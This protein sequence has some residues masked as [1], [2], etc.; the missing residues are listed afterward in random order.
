MTT[1][2]GQSMDAKFRRTLA[3]LRTQ[4][5]AVRSKQRARAKI[6]NSLAKIDIDIDMA[7]WA[8]AEALARDM[9]MLPNGGAHDGTYKARIEAYSEA[10]GGSPAPVTIKAYREMGT[11][12]PKAKRK[13]TSWSAHFILKSR[14]ELLQ[15]GMTVSEAEYALKGRYGSRSRHDRS[16]ARGLEIFRSGIRFLRLAM[17]QTEWDAASPEQLRERDEL[18]GEV[19]AVLARAVELPRLKA[20]A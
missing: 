7:K 14:P 9:P 16:A 6:R 8:E 18:E 12:W 17:D 1:T 2:K 5:T 4:E 19:E 20:V 13:N 3:T 15:D 10:L 11:I